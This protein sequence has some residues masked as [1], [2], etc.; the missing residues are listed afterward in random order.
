[1]KD[2]SIVSVIAKTEEEKVIK[3]KEEKRVKRR[4]FIFLENRSKRKNQDLN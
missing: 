4:A 1:V 2:Y 3:K